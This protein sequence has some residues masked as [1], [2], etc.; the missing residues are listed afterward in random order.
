LNYPKKQILRK[1]S[2]KK[3]QISERESVT[4]LDISKKELEGKLD[5][6]EF[7]KLEK[8]DCSNNKITCLKVTNS[9][10]LITE[11]NLEKNKKL[12][13]LNIKNNN[14]SK[15]NLFFCSHL[16]NL[17][18]LILGNDDPEKIK[19]DIFNSFIG[20]FEHLK[21]MKKLEKLIIDNSDL[22]AGVEYLPN[23]LVGVNKYQ[24]RKISYSTEK[25]PESKVTEVKLQLDLFTSGNQKY[26]LCKG[27]NQLDTG[28]WK[29]Q[30]CNFNK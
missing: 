14:F 20:S 30:S 21:G 27:C 9:S 7:V 8:L 19:N 22:S 13:V 3:N 29:C 6:S 23:N 25:R 11:L 15:Q 1:V 16:V 17:K 28:G 18:Q 24:V 5:L 2:N 12:Q 26:G 4:E 10:N